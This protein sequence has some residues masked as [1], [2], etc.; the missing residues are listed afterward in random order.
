MLTYTYTYT[1]ELINIYIYIYDCWS[2]PG[3]CKETAKG[4]EVFVREWTKATVTLDCK[5]W[6][7]N[8]SMH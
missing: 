3:V 4:S 6:L 7:G 2:I 8:I 5:N 1:S